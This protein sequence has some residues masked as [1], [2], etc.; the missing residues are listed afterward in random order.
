M[1]RK[2]TRIAAAEVYNQPQLLHPNT[3]S[4]ICAYIEKRNNGYVWDKTLENQAEKI[5]E[6]LGY[7]SEG[8][9]RCYKLLQQLF[10]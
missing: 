7:D 6:Q 1:P 10:L 8:N 2:I 5:N 4:N 9:W 3:L